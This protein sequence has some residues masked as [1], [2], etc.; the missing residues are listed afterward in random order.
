MAPPPSVALFHGAA[1]SPRVWERVVAAL[2]PGYCCV[3]TDLHDVGRGIA[4]HRPAVAVGNGVGSFFAAEHAPFRGLVVAGPVGLAGAGHARL[5]WLS[6]HRPGAALLRCV[7]TTVGRRK[8]LRDQLADPDADPEAAA[9]LVDGLRRARRF[10]QLARWN[11]PSRLACLRDIA[12]P[13]VV[14]WGE[15]EGVL[16]ITRAD[17]FMAHLPPHAWLVRVPGAAHALPL[18]R[19]D[20]VAA[21]VRSLA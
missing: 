21:A 12:C 4:I 10:H 3:A 5:N 2:S 14:L 1:G 9:I 13:V 15:R 8:F 11:A 6:H 19:P 16:P 17:E 7:G 20:L 18:E